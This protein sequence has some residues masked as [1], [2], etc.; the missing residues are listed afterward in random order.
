MFFHLDPLWASPD[1]TF[2]AI[3]NY[4]PLSDW[5]DGDTHLDAQVGWVGPYDMGYLQGNVAGGEGYDW[6]YASAADRTAQVRTSITD[7]FG[8]AWVFRTKDLVNWWGSRTSTAPAGSRRAP[9]RLGARV[10]ADPL[11]RS[12]CPCVDRGMNQPN[13]FVDPKSSESFLPYFSRGWP[14]ESVQRRHAEALIGYWSDPA[15]NPAATL[16]S[17]RMLETDEIALWTW[18]AR[19]F[20][21]FRRGVMSG[22][23]RRTGASAIG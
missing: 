6:F 10:Q 17:G 15:N 2:I 13:V 19:P 4:L 1:V 14:D 9:H 5:R 3:D 8:K 21:A 23:M 12:R 11:H 7:G 18:D 22:R 20:P 16:Y